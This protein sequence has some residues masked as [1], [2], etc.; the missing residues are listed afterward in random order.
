MAGQLLEMMTNFACASKKTRNVYVFQ[1]ELWNWKVRENMENT[2]GASTKRTREEETKK[3]SEQS[4]DGKRRNEKGRN[5]QKEMDNERG[6]ARVKRRTH[7]ATAQSLQRGFVAQ[8]IFTGLHH[9]GQ[10]RV[11]ALL[12]FLGLLGHSSHHRV[13]CLSSFSACV[14]VTNIEKYGTI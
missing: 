11:D 14:I 9:Q 6:E 5:I 13:K 7:L 1:S 10:A 3:S 12:R 4:R 8:C 2:D